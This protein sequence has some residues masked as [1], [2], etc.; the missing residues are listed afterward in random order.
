M[1]SKFIQRFVGAAPETGIKEYNMV[2]VT[3]ANNHANQKRK[4]VELKF[5]LTFSYSQLRAQM[6]N[7]LI[8]CKQK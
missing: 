1:H 5:L 2:W 6:R 7:M 3:E 4:K 8:L